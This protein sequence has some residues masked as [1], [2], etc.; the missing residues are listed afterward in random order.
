MFLKNVFQ[1]VK[2]VENPEGAHA[3][4]ESYREGLKLVGVGISLL[5]PPWCGLHK[6]RRDF[7][8]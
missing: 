1:R 2:G 7:I 6:A 5:C 4:P 3:C 8:A